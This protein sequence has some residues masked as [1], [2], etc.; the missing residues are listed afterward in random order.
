MTARMRRPRLAVITGA[1]GGIGEAVARHL[2]GAGYAVILAVGPSHAAESRARW[3]SEL[4]DRVLAV[5]S[6]DL[7][8]LA[9][10]EDFGNAVAREHR[11]VHAL[12]NCAAHLDRSGIGQTT[13]AE[14]ARSFA[15]NCAAPVVLSRALAESLRAA[16]GSIVSLASI[17]AQV[18]GRDRIAYTASK[19]ALV[20]VTRALAV[21]LAPD[22]R[23]NCILPGL[24]DTRMNE[25]L[26]ARVALL[27]ATLARI[28]QHRLGRP[29]ELAA[30]VA[31]LV[32]EEASYVTGTVLAVDGGVLAR[33]PLPAAD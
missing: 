7:E 9:T 30:A 10:V 18:A 31:F 17:T 11:E 28:P 23:V 14:L 16:R 20:G 27:E 32:S 26:K 6:V 12:V 25:P 22:V 33:T 19:A 2:L 8:D 15:V 5:D 13:P 21:E 1:S 24:F 29:E 4:G 3:A